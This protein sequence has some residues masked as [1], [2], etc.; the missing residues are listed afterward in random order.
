MRKLNFLYLILPLFIF[1]FAACSDDDNLPQEPETPEVPEV[2]CDYLDQATYIG[3][4]TPQL[5]AMGLESQGYGQFVPLL[6]SRVHIYN[7]TY[8]TTYNDQKTKASGAL[9]V[10]E[11]LDPA[12]PTVVYTHGTI[13]KAEA[14][15]ENLGGLMKYSLEVFL[16]LT[17]SSINSCAVLVPDY[18]GYGASADINHP[19]LHKESLAQAS[20]DFI[21]ACAEYSDDKTTENWFNTELFISGYSEGG[22]AAVALQQK[23]QETSATGLTISKVL[24]GAG[25]YDQ[26]AFTK[27]FLQKE[28]A[29][30]PHNIS[31]YLW[32][33]DMYK[34]NYN[35]SKPY[36]DIF[37]DA[38]NKILS[39]ANYPMGYFETEKLAINTDPAKL[40]KP[41]FVTGALT[42]TDT[43]LTGILKTNSF[44]EYTPT[45]S[46]I[47]IHGM[48]D[49]WVYPSNATN[50]YEA[51]AA[52]GCKVKL[53]PIPGTDHD[54]TLPYY[55]TLLLGR[56]AQYK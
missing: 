25:A 5:L 24:A 42:D 16:G 13:V 49:K 26:Y 6:K 45:D 29:Q 47:F 12:K 8:F 34:N 46:L 31:S 35:Y 11:N 3:M 19:Y 33:F 32:V 53:Y 56:L 20:F 23:L 4:T 17:A 52:K 21:R 2:E 41:D 39:D 10:A 22:Y 28:G 27:E 38:D 7:V 18:L 48:A 15:S 55:L 40:F 50:V 37:S 44:N 43:E 54:T 51:M 36:A 1:I 9:F 30:D 14:P